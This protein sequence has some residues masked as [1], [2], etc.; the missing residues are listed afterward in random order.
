MIVGM[1]KNRNEEGGFWGYLRCE[2]GEREMD[3]RWELFWREWL[4]KRGLAWV[5][6]VKVENGG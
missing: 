2:C 5:N 3:R 4:V 1:E 6:I